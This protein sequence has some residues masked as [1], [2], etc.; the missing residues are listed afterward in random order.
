MILC[1]KKRG[2]SKAVTIRYC[3]H[4]KLIPAQKEITESIERTNGTLKSPTFRSACS[5]QLG[6]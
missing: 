5:R 4:V 6:S 3:E 1:A 2:S